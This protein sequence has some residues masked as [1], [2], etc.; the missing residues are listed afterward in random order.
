MGPLRGSLFVTLLAASA[1]A[2]QHDPT[3]AIVRELTGFDDT[4][5]HRRLV[6]L[7]KDAVRS[8]TDDLGADQLEPH[9][10]RERLRI[11]RE[12]GPPAGTAVA[13]LQEQIVYFPRDVLAEFLVTIAALAP[14]RPA[15][16]IYRFEIQTKIGEIRFEHDEAR[17]R[18]AVNLLLHRMRER[19]SLHHS[20]SLAELVRAADGYRPF[21]VELAIELIA[22]RGFEGFAA[23]PVLRKLVARSDPKILLTDKTVPLRRAAARAIFAMETSPQDAKVLRGAMLG[24]APPASPPLPERARARIEQLIGELADPTL[25]DN[26]S[27]N[28]VALGALVVPFLAAIVGDEGHAAQR[29][30]ALDVLRRLGPDAG[31]GV[32][33]LFAALFRA[34]TNAT[35]SILRA[36]AELAPWSRHH[37]PF[38]RFDST[39][40]LLRLYDRPIGPLEDESHT[41]RCSA[42]HKQLIETLAV[43]PAAG[44]KEFETWLDATLPHRAMFAIA[45]LERRGAEARPLLQQL[46]EVRLTSKRPNEEDAVEELRR[47][48]ARATLK[49]DAP[50]GRFSKQARAW[51]EA[52]GAQ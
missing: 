29:E 42:R 26:A 39:D 23:A 46:A 27:D 1:T 2:Q 13:A 45:V 25:R 9:R 10:L 28:L 33:L 22:K 32:P 50:D 37:V 34:P 15:D 5:A 3:A 21:R 6:T 24:E 4:D 30:A 7:G 12:I 16:V 52:R 36:L 40:G 48:A 17:Q 19:F 43:D 41:A 35:P 49:I 38:P 31:E 14:Y 44:S 20:A 8:L 18:D 11:L 47:A 51:L